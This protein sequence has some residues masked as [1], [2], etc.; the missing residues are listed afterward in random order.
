MKYFIKT[1]GCQQNESDSQRISSILEKNKLKETNNI[2]QADI[3]IIN[4]CSVRQSAI[5]RVLGLKPKILKIKKEK[6]VKAIL[7]GCILEQDKNKFKEY[8][9]LIISI[10][11]ISHLP[12]IIKGKEYKKTNESYFSI[13][14]KTK[15]KIVALIP[16]MTGCNNYCTYCVVPYTRG[17]EVSRKPKE[18]IKEIKKEIKKGAKEIWLLGQNVNSYKYNFP[19]LLNQTSKIPGNFWIRFTSPHPKDF[20]EELIKAMAESKK[21]TK[22]LNLPL[23]SG[24]DK[25]LKKMNRPYTIKKYKDLVKKIRKKIPDIAIS[26]DII[27]GFPG[28]TKEQFN[29]T[30]RALKE[31]KYDMAYISQYSSRKGTAA[32][33]MLDTVSKKE[34]KKRD[35]ALT[36]IIKKT[37]LEKNK[38]Y[39]GTI[40][41]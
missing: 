26:T 9:D 28:E 6:P 17:K 31:I 18:I 12:Q 27:V 38:K 19:K 14:L 24:D 22:Y 1:F 7:T 23:Q 41:K 36:E 16:I 32:S 39:I 34:K 15:G 37:A 13:P 25:I 3:V 40:Q 4:A 29:K 33:K 21:I 2:Y 10:K 11:D 30:A 8:F 5:D 35:K 20:T